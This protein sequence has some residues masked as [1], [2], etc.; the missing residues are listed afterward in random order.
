MNTCNDL[1]GHIGASPDRQVGGAPGPTLSCE[2]G[3][4]RE[5][6]TA[7]A[8]GALNQVQERGF[9]PACVGSH[10]SFQEGLQV[11]PGDVPFLLQVPG[12]V[13]HTP[14]LLSS[15]TLL[16]L[17]LKASSPQMAYLIHG[18]TEAWGG[19]GTE[20]ASTCGNSL[21]SPEEVANPTPSDSPLRV[22]VPM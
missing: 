2:W 22:C 15:P 16:F 21:A 7:T 20:L 12:N 11:P 18:E 8:E 19:P 10:G 6:G 14:D 17:Y 9:E 13:S 4:G 5:V 1:E 3:Y